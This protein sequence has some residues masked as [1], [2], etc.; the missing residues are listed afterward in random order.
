[1]NLGKK[2]KGEGKKDKGKGNGRKGKNFHA[3]SLDL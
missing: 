2:T 3:F 1:M